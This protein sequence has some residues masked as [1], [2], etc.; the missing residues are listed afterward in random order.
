M[1]EWI[2]GVC[3]SVCHWI[4]AGIR[5]SDSSDEEV[6]SVIFTAF[7]GIGDAFV[8]LRSREMAAAIKTDVDGTYMF[9]LPSAEEES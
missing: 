1:F 5:R 6:D 4:A 2:A 3:S 9:F 7:G 8:P